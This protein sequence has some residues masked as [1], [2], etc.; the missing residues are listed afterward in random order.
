MMAYYSG[1]PSVNEAHRSLEDVQFDA[2]K[3]DVGH[4]L[5]HF[6]DSF[7]MC[8]VH[9]H[10]DLL[11][12]E[13]MA[14]G[15]DGVCKPRLTASGDKFY[16][17]R[18]DR[19][20]KAYE[21]S[22]VPQEPV[23]EVL[24]QAFRT[25][26]PETVHLG[27]YSRQGDDEDADVVEVTEANDSERAHRMVPRG[28]EHDLSLAMFTSWF[29]EKGGRKCN[30]PCLESEGI[31]VGEGHPAMKEGAPC[32]PWIHVQKRGEEPAMKEGAPCFPWI[33]VQKKGEEPAMKE[34]APCFPWIHVQKNAELGPME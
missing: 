9:H 8:L 3:A 25:L 4:L 11:D 12:G 7:G 19:H 6:G 28:P 2:I 16:P 27:L 33:H 21:F 32:F 5:A 15:E 10:F 18:F 14:E 29:N 34:G 1:L 23:P 31:D 22:T 24:F 17:K 30:G 13:V 26:V 20:G